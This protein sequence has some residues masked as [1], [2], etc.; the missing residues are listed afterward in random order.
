MLLQ[1]NLRSI[2][3]EI[4]KVI[5]KFFSLPLPIQAVLVDMTYNLGAP[6][7]KKFK[8]MIKCMNDNAYGCVISEMINSNWYKT[9]IDRAIRDVDLAKDFMQRCQQRFRY[10]P[11]GSLTRNTCSVKGTIQ[12]KTFNLAL[13]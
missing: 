3:N 2:P 13:V 9:Q 10:T 6:R 7:F 4:V 5:P 8:E 1:H 12:C 11:V